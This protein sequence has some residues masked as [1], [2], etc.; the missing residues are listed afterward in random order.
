VKRIS[1][2]ISKN[3]IQAIFENKKMQAPFFGHKKWVKSYARAVFEIGFRAGMAYYKQTGKDHAE[4]KIKQFSIKA[5]PYLRH[6]DTCKTNYGYQLC[7]CG[8]NR[9]MRGMI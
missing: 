5:K 6:K 8:F 7:S 1:D 4:F 9:T 3:F 2:V